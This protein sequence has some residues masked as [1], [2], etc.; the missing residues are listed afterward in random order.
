MNLLH[1]PVGVKDLYGEDLRS[2][3]LIQSK[4]HSLFNDSGYEDIAT[5]T[6]EYFDIFSGAVGTTPSKDLYKFYDR[7]GETVVLR[8]D[9]TPSIARF[10][11]KCMAGND[12]VLKLTYKGNAFSETKVHQGKLKETT[13]M[14]VEY[15][16]DGSIDADIEAIKLAILSLKSTGLEAFKVSVGH[17]DFFKGLCRQ[18]D[19]DAETEL[20]LR[21]LISGKNFAEVATYLK[22][23]SMMDK[24]AEAFLNLEN[25]YG[26]IGVL[27]SIKEVYC[28]QLSIAAVDR[29]TS[30]YKALEAEGLCSYITFDLSLLNKYK[31]Y[32]SVVFNAYTYGVG[33][34]ILKGGRYDSLLK[35][36][37]T[38]RPAIGFVVLIDD[39]CQAIKAQNNENYNDYITIAL[40]KGRLAD[41]TMDLLEKIGISCEEVKDKS[42]RKLIFTN[43]DMKVRFFLSK[44][45]DVPTY[46]EYGAADIGVVGEDTILEEDR[47]ILEV[48]DLG[49]GKCRMCVCGK[50]EK[51]AL[52][53]SREQIRVATKYPEIARDYFYNTKH[54]TV[55]LIKLNGSVELGPIVNLADVIV[56][57]VETGSTLK[58]NGLEVLEE[59]VPLSARMVVNRVSMQMKYER[60]R[61]IIASLK[62]QLD[63]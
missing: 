53:D 4:I 17:I 39:L 37:G 34:S 54:Q 2:K 3:E 33:D 8:P 57:I 49:F 14:G 1:T 36:F 48:M 61:E 18:Y 15:L 47:R 10:A 23:I 9:F 43:E 24:A 7:D 55:E 46:V 28:N 5:P 56:D 35:Q 58:E 31:Y 19:I 26:G 12:G 13:Q 50:S 51:K 32:T 25:L 42:T 29:L 44:G 30:I 41:K 38:D 11:S 45:P 21:E 6:F 40:T 52:L 60:I 16:G 20:E 63:A 62:E 22:R 59:I 27:Q